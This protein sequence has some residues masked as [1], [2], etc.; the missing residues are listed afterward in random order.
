ML[1]GRL[2]RDISPVIDSPKQAGSN[3]TSRVACAQVETS[4][5]IMGFIVLAG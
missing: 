2:A 1:N 3:G 4:D 5:L